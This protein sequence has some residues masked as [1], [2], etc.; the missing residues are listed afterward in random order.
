MGNVWLARAAGPAGFEKLVVLKTIRPNEAG[1]EAMTQ[2]F[3]REARVAALLSHP[4]CVQV[5]DL[6]EEGG[7][8]YIA[9]EYLDGFSLARVLR[10]GAE[11]GRPMPSEIV[12]RIV[13]DAAAGLDY[14]HTLKDTAGRPLA[15]VHR[16][17][18]LDNILIT[19][20]GQ[21]KLLDF[22]IAKATL[23]IGGERTETGHLKGK[24]A[25]MAPEYLRG[26]AIDARA[27]VFALGVV[28]FRALTG[29]RPFD[30]EI[31]VQVMTAIV[32]P[33]PAPRMRDVGAELPEALDD[34]IARAL[35]KTPDERFATARAFRAA[36]SAAVPD[37]ADG[38]AVAAYLSSLWVED[39][40]DRVAVRR[41][42][43]G[44]QSGSA[45]ALAP[46]SA[47]IE[48]GMAMDS[49]GRPSTSAETMASSPTTIDAPAPRGRSRAVIASVAAAGVVVAGAGVYVVTRGRG[50]VP[51]RADATVAI[52][53]PADGGVDAPA[54]P[55]HKRV[56]VLPFAATGTPPPEDYVVAGVRDELTAKLSLLGQITLAPTKASDAA[57]AQ[58]KDQLARKLGVDAVVTGSVSASGD[59]LDIDLA[60]V[61]TPSGRQIWTQR[62][63]GVLG[64]LLTL[65]DQLGHDVI[66]ALV[67]PTA[68]ELARTLGHPTESFDAYDLY[69]KGRR[70]GRNVNDV[71]GQ[72]AAIALFEQALA[73]D[74][75]FALAYA[76]I[77]DAAARIYRQTK[78]ATWSTRSLSAA[79][80]AAR[81]DDK[82]AE[83]HASLG[84]AYRMV[85]R[86]AES[87]A[88]LRTAT[89]LQPGSDE[90]Y[91]HLG[92]ALMEMGR[93]ADG[94]AALQKAAAVNPYYF[95][96]YGALS[97][98]YSRVGELDKALAADQK[99]LELEPDDPSVHNAIGS[100][101]K[102][103]GKLADAVAEFEKS[104]ALRPS[105]DAYA[106]LGAS[107]GEMGKFDDAIA[108]FE[109]STAQSPN[110]S[111][112]LGGLADAYW[113]SRSSKARPLYDKAIAMALKELA[114]NPR[115]PDLRGRIA[116]WYAKRGDASNAAKM[117]ASARAIDKSNIDLMYYDVVVKS[118][119]SKFKEA[120]QLLDAILSTGNP[121]DDPAIDPDLAA[122][123]KDPR[124]G[125]LL[126][127]YG[128][129]PK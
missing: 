75:K 99:M 7:T 51:P 98:A 24:T 107:Y 105:A 31:E 45:P 5:F 110:S 102:R 57:A 13:I 89:E 22:G 62:Y 15:L 76:G 2:M 81:L 50:A 25:Y 38:D 59:H 12:A 23:G 103:A 53:R 69:L 17:V 71:K 8:Y 122:L 1:A 113:W 19:F 92:N 121:S 35:A 58:P 100:D 32:S 67:T 118:C 72:Q 11:L 3:L 60:V 4:N 43:A 104:V 46:I 29:L 16:D 77:A 127:K 6:G 78:L 55:E 47:S 94:I 109:K 20:T 101:Y 96:N 26:E 36:I 125:A 123:R 115:D 84:M 41:L 30:G 129:K 9:M 80:Q 10:R 27:D 40:P 64:D 108:A 124:F 85:G 42:I 91:R 112:Y 18:S 95:A 52:A 70:A 39:D 34:A 126:E 63:T 54:P 117:I 65:E 93:S 44:E 68:D 97:N 56:A 33:T 37:A 28:A 14:A 128:K 86:N 114:V 88:E 61:E 106:N 119:A 49:S 74:R 83:V 66:A 73:K 116:T 79:Q 82:L 87:I 48:R 21:T 111:S 120:I 90:A